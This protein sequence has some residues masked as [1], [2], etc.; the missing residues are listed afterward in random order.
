MVV[1]TFQSLFLERELNRFN[2]RET[3]PTIKDV[4]RLAGVSPATVSHVINDS[5]PISQETRRR[6]LEAI[7]VLGYQPSVIARGLQAGQ[8]RMLGY[9][10]VPMPETKF[11]PILDQFL[12][13]MAEA[14][15]RHDYH[16]LTFPAPDPHREIDVYRQMVGSRRV[17]GFILS[18]TTL[19]DA[20][21]QLLMDAKFP[22]VAFGRSN[23]EWDFP[24]IDV[25]GAEGIRLAVR[26]L[27]ALGHH[28]IACLAWPEDSLTGQFR[29]Q[30]YYDGLGEAG[31]SQ[32]SKWV[33]RIENDYAQAYAAAKE[34]LSLPA[35][36]RPTAIT[37]LA[38]LMAIGVLNAAADSGARVGQDL[39][40][41][42]F[43]D[44]PV[45][46]FLRPPLTSLRQPIAEIG[47]LVVQMLLALLQGEPLEEPQRLLP[48]VLIVRESTRLE[49]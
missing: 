35:A 45:A 23:P 11:D 21:I 20:R 24:F 40:I 41:T 17:D 8:S 47:D 22:F 26:H 38:D 27:V 18:N 6:V 25:D 14:A 43:D 3:M 37:C 16:L 30:G 28:R 5:A 42:G 31:L 49:G 12:E 9:S 19:D 2:A 44:A 7:Q 36:E 1:E 4:A 15:A 34:L 29:L 10:W 33:L 48:P 32:N 46:R 13:N 39:A